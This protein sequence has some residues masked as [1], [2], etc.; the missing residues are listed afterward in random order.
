MTRWVFV[1][2]APDGLPPPVLR[3]LEN[4]RRR[5]PGIE[6]ETR[7]EPEQWKLTD[8]LDLAAL[9]DIFGP[10]PSRDD[11]EALAIA[12]SAPHR[13]SGEGRAQPPTS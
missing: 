7:G 10:A 12:D 9:E 3:H 13:R 11:A 8:R 4:Q 6:I 1:H 5:Y 2:N